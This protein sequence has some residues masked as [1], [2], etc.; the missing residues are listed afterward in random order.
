MNSERTEKASP[1]R[2]QKA[3]QEGDRPRSRELLSSAALLAGTLTLGW[4]ARTWLPLWTGVYHDAMELML[5]HEM[6]GDALS[7]SM[8]NLLIA[9]CGPCLFVMLAAAGG[10]E[11]VWMAVRMG[12]STK[13]V[14]SMECTLRVVVIK[15]KRVILIISTC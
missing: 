12:L 5:T 15:E 2:R 6:S 10:R 14:L 4:A 11:E 13:G 7:T 3:E 9:A 8:R 1:R